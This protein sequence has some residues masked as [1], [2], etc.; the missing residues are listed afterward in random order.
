MTVVRLLPVLPSCDVQTRAVGYDDVVTAVGRWVEDGLVL[1]HE[2]DGDAGGESA[3][4]GRCGVG[5]GF[6]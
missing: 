5:S 4:G 6:G 1:A 2:D 3:E